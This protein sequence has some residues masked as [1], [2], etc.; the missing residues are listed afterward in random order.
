MNLKSQFNQNFYTPKCEDW[1]KKLA[2]SCLFCRLNQDRKVLQ[3][4]GSVREYQNNL[5]PGKIWNFDVLFMP[6]SN[7][8][9]R[10]I[11][12]MVET[13]TSYI[14]A[15]PIKTLKTKPVAEAFRTFCR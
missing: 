15:I 11:L 2:Q 6:R 14:C 13:L 10:Y 1:V 8:G 5:I 7:S 12:T 4:K 9:Y 3:T